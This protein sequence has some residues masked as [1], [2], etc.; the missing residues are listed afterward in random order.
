MEAS[1]KQRLR[2]FEFQSSNQ[3]AHFKCLRINVRFAPNDGLLHRSN[4]RHIRSPHRRA[5]L[6]RVA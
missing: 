4:Y 6:W 3:S 2:R 1:R 5:A